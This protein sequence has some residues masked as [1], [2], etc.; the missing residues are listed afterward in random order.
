MEEVN[1]GWNEK[2]GRE[3]A[4]RR[5]QKAKK[6]GKKEIPPENATTELIGVERGQKMGA[7]K[8]RRGSAKKERRGNPQTQKTK[9]LWEKSL[10]PFS[11]SYNDDGA[12]SSE[13]FKYIQIPS[14]LISTQKG[15]KLT[16]K[17]KK[18]QNELQELIYGITF[19]TANFIK[20][21]KI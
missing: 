10:Q 15:K 2:K 12:L 4:S 7:K 16:P 8:T 21:L 13:S 19:P 3:K 6:K 1:F 20:R 17:Q 18:E 14:S 9:L 11:P 5:S